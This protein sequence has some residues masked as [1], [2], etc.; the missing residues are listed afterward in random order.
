MR[1][2]PKERI[3]FARVSSRAITQPHLSA[4]SNNV[5]IRFGARSSLLGSSC[6]CVVKLFERE[7][8]QRHHTE[9]AISTSFLVA[10][11]YNVFIYFCWDVV[12]IQL[13]LLPGYLYKTCANG[14]QFHFSFTGSSRPRRYLIWWS[15]FTAAIW[16]IIMP[17]VSLSLS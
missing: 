14:G 11:A 3:C 9:T 2:S 17:I 7:S 16:N 6:V 5:W 1:H 10:R 8:A 4:H 12:A 15:K 13:W